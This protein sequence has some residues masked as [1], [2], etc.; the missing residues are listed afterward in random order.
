MHPL[1]RAS[2]E[3]ICRARKASGTILEVGATPS[4]KTLLCLPSLAHAARRVG[5]NLAGPEGH[6]H[7]NELY[8]ANAHDLSRFADES[9]DVVLCNAVLE[10]DPRFWR[11][12][13]EMRRV[14]RKGGL[15]AIGVPGY[16]IAAWEERLHNLLAR[17]PKLY[18]WSYRHLNVLVAGTFTLGVHDAPGDFYRFSEQAMREVFM[19]G[20]RDVEIHRLMIPPRIIGVGVRA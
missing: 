19:E 16:A 8:Q 9:F 6:F 13:S 10:H 5:V 2:F 11:S 20:M 14:C 3:E 4:R 18:Q 1:V 17:V 7:G 12:L 15:L